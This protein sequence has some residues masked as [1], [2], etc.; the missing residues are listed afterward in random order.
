[1]LIVLI[2]SDQAAAS[3]L[4]VNFC[5]QDLSFFFPYTYEET[6]RWPQFVQ[7]H[8]RSFRSVSLL[9]YPDQGSKH[10]LFILAVFLMYA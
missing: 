6:L 3:L 4:F 1:M 5:I 8:L 7:W 9:W 2:L 10:V